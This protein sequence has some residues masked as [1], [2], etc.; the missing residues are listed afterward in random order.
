MPPEAFTMGEKGRI[1]VG[2]EPHLA[3]LS[4]V[5]THDRVAV[6]PVYI[7]S[8]WPLLRGSHAGLVTL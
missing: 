6:P 2:G 5:D 1:G 3:P 4:E 8:S 7:P